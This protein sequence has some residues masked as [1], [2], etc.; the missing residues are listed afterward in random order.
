MMHIRGLTFYR[1]NSPTVDFGSEN[2]CMGKFPNF[3]LENFLTS[4]SSLFCATF[5]LPIA[6]AF[7]NY[8][9]FLFAYVFPFRCQTKRSD[10]IRR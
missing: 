2:R 7:L 4:H 10:E 5:S 8:H 9:F 1:G 6:P 3:V